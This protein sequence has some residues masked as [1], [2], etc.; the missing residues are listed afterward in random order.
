MAGLPYQEIKKRCE[1]KNLI[2]P[3]YEKTIQSGKSYGF[4]ESGYDIRIK[5]ELTIY[6][7]TIG[8]LFIN[9]CA[10]LWSKI[11]IVNY[12]EPRPSFILASSIERFNMQDDI[13]AEV[14]DKSSWI[15]EGLSVHNTVIEPGWTGI[16]TLELK[17]VGYM[18]I[19]I[20]SGDPIAQI[21]FT[22]LAKPTIRP[23][24]GKYQ[25]QPD[26]PVGSIKE[27]NTL[28]LEPNVEY[29]IRPEYPT[30]P[31]NENQWSSRPPKK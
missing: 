12:V 5:Q 30:Q 6:P 28:Y 2:T 20:K 22:K 18:P 21:L 8:N 9:A 31:I 15:R 7:V 29:K 26:R 13:R 23:Y 11:R 14:K 24:E 1:E 25:N 27:E 17:N 10:W 16:L 19:Y 4:S 3:Y